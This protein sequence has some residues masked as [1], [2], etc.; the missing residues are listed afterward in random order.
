MD[1]IVENLATVPLLANLTNEQLQKL[2]RACECIF[3]AP[4]KVLVEQGETADAAYLCLD[5]TV[6]REQ[7][8]DTNHE[9]DVSS[10]PANSIVLE[11]AMIVETE[12]AARFVAEAHARVL[13]I[14]REKL[15]TL[16]E[17][18]P[19]LAS[20]MSATLSARLTDMAE[21]MR[22][23][24]ASFDEPADAAANEPEAPATSDAS[25]AAS[26]ETARRDGEE[27]RSA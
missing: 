26:S 25:H 12:A 16:L 5:D 20:A 1:Q 4:G 23:A 2:T 24:V 11:L 27:Q 9:P 7:A 10:V 3:V 13:K 21:A 17:T 15:L 18:D 19:A 6:L 8:S 14:S 22:E